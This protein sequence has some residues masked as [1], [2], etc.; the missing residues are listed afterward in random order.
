ML[1]ACLPA[2]RRSSDDDGVPI[3]KFSEPPPNEF[4]CLKRGKI[5]AS[6]TTRLNFN[7][8]SCCFSFPS[9]EAVLGRK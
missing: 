2:A 8:V 3:M 7:R 9:R 5:A 6:Q 1:V 4:V